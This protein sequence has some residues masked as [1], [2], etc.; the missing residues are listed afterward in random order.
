MAEV[1][2]L[3]GMV[4]FFKEDTNCLEKGELK[5]KSGFLLDVKLIGH[6]VKAVV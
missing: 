1:I 4:K 5:Y 3:I 2:S 6:E